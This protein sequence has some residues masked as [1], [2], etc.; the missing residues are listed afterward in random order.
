[1][2]VL[3]RGRQQARFH[4]A[5]TIL[6]AGLNDMTKSQIMKKLESGDMDMSAVCEVSQGEVEIFVDAGNGR[7]DDE[8]T[9]SAVSTA[10]KILGW[11]GGYRTGYGGWV[12]Q[13]HPLEL[14]DWNSP[15]SR[16]HY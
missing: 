10:E 7:A 14:G 3:I 5:E 1:M 6:D 8:K 2:V 15:A 16:W 4:F 12:I 9:D 11:K 13:E